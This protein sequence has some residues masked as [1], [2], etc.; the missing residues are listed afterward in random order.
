[1]SLARRTNYL[2]E[3]LGELS[4]EED[5]IAVDLAPHEWAQIEAWW[6]R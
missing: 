5:K 6:I 4:V 3:T 2:G 1:V